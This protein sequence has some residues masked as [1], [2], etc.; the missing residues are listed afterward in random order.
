MSSDIDIMLQVKSGEIDKLGLLFERYKKNL[1]GY[2]YRNTG[3]KDISEDLVQNVFVRILKYRNKFS[4]QGK[5]T[6]WMYRIAHNEIV[7]NFRKNKKYQSTDDFSELN[8]SNDSDTAKETEEK[9][10]VHLL[11]KA[12]HQ[13]EESKREILV[14][15]K[16]Q[17]LKYK[18]IGKIIGCSEGSVKVR[19]FRALS[20]LK[21][22]YNKL[23]G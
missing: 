10:S 21:D 7:D 15:S 3:S 6:S 17:G 4:G 9:E 2:F 8:I 13:L 1:F 16:Y 20:E 22:I 18:E 5:F 11:K 19:I 23:Q 12:L 14:L